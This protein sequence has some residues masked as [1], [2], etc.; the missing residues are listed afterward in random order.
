M[1]K[2]MPCALPSPFI[3]SKSRPK[4]EGVSFDIPNDNTDATQQEE[5]MNEEEGLI[6]ISSSNQDTID[7]A[8]LTGDYG[9]YISLIES[10][11]RKKGRQ[12]DAESTFVIDSID[13]AEHHKSKKSITSVISYSSTLF[14]TKW[15]NEQTTKAG[16]SHNILT[17]QQ[18][19]GKETA[20]TILPSV[21]NYFQSK[22]KLKLK[23]QETTGLSYYFYDM[24][25][26][27][28]LYL[29]CEHSLWNRKHHPFL[30]C[31]CKRGEGVVNSVSHKCII[32]SHEEDVYLHNRS[33]RRFDRKRKTLQE[34]ESY[35]RNDHKSW[36]DEHNQGVSHFGIHP[37]LL[38]RTEIRFDVFHL[39]CSITKRIMSYLRTFMLN[40]S[41]D[42]GN[43]FCSSILAK[44]WNPFHLFVWRTNKA[45][46]SFQ[47][48][49]LALFVANASCIQDFLEKKLVQNTACLDFVQALKSWVFMFK[50]LGIS[51]V[52]PGQEE[53]SWYKN[54]LQLF[55][56]EAKNFYEKGKNTFL[57]KSSVGSEETCYMHVL[58]YY[59]PHI[60]TITYERHT[61]G[62]GIF[63][64]Q[65]FERRNKESKNVYK[66]FSNNKMNVMPSLLG[67]LYD[68]FETDKNAY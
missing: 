65:G 48:N 36:I 37:D 5:N 32:R 27:K 34:G 28:M 41:N 7:G 39:K 62:V 4:I 10:K 13:G 9:D 26:C 21:S 51:Y 68:V 22:R 58:S 31:K 25:D 66:R 33:M 15:I 50:F 17:W 16:S 57:S 55:E 59:I 18:L 47:G 23:Q 67:R 1:N 30:L 20:N 40:Q 46:S 45:F 8:K 54:Q 42:I 63:N 2:V 6:Y 35:T 12:I 24:H 61:V 29:L 49:E 53:S 19:R 38:P 43:Q 44:F 64:M 60:A 3:L 11:H 56:D 52:T 14:T